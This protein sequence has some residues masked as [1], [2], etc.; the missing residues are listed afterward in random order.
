MDQLHRW[1]SAR[2]I[3]WQRNNLHPYHIFLEVFA[4]QYTFNKYF[5]QG[6]NGTWIPAIVSLAL[7]MQSFWG[8][9]STLR[10]FSFLFVAITIILCH[11]HA[12]SLNYV[13]S[14]CI[15]KLVLQKTVRGIFSLSRHKTRMTAVYTSL[16]WTPIWK[17]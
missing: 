1:Y 15:N 11:C 4:S 3:M 6:I 5:P 14:Y 8:E 13:L 12:I 17:K 16:G 7:G 9:N 2:T 10:I